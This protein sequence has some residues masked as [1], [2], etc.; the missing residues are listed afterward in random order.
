MSEEISTRREFLK[1]AAM[2]VGMGGFLTYLASKDNIQR[3]ALIENNAADLGLKIDRQELERVIRGGHKFGFIIK[4]VTDGRMDHLS[5]MGDVR[6]ADNTQN[7]RIAVNQPMADFIARESDLANPSFP[8]RMLFVEDWL[9]Q[10]RGEDTAG[11]TAIADDEHDQIVVIS[12]KAAAYKAFKDLE[13]T[14]TPITDYF[15]GALSYFI[16]RHTAHEWAHA[17]RQTKR[18]YKKGSGGQ[19]PDDILDSTHPQIFRFDEAY[20]NLYNHALSQGRGDSALIFAAN[21]NKEVNLQT[22]RAKILREAK[23]RGLP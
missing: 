4:Y 3:T 10:Q 18:L 19:M 22:Y 14:N 2:V 20:T 12:L 7:F 8:T 17:G 11:F 6:V 5:T 21:L 23:L 13:R 16:S 9:E 15:N 1:R